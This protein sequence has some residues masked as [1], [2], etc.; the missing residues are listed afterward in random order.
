MT[1]LHKSTTSKKVVVLVTLGVA[2]VAAIVI[3]AAIIFSGIINIA[4]TVPESGI[5]K[6]VLHETM[7]NS[8][9][10]HAASIKA[11]AVIDDNMLAEGFHHFR[12]M[13]TICHGAPGVRQ[14]EIGEGLRPAPPDLAKAAPDMSDAEI[15]WITK[16]GIRMTGM[17]SFG[18][19]HSERELWGI[20]AV[21]RKLPK[22]TPEAYRAWERSAD[23][24]A[25]LLGHHQHEEGDEHHH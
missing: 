3:G 24:E 14:S 19:T 5:T 9:E 12:E 7:E 13:C 22:L 2:A 16:N 6:W 21:V 11:P 4:A 17:P 8:V 20:G 23:E 15:Y 10:R 18:K 25:N 1:A